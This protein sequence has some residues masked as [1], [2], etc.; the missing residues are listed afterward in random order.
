MVISD[1][2]TIFE[3]LATHMPH[4]VPV[5]KTYPTRL[6]VHLTSGDAINGYGYSVTLYLSVEVL[7]HICTCCGETQ[8]SPGYFPCVG[9]R[10][11]HEWRKIADVDAGS[12]PQRYQKLNEQVDAWQQRRSEQG[13]F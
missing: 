7:T 9:H 3:F 2:T 1:I 8:F 6:N 5:L 10:W 11:T 13:K 12:I 4:V